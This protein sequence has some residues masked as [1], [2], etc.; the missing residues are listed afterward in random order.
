M[1]NGDSGELSWFALRVIP[2]RE[3]MVKK[4]LVRIGK[5]AFIKLERRFGKWINGE[6][7]DRPYC[8]APAYVFVGL[9]DEENPWD[10][11]HTCHLIRSVVSKEQQ[12]AKINPLILA[13]FLG[14]DDFD[15]P[16]YFKYFRTKEPDFRVGDMVRIDNPSFLGFKLP[17]K[18]I[19]RGEAIFDL[20]MFAGS[21]PA[22]I[23][24]PVEQCYKAA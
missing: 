1:S 6:R 11:V 12:P 18:D 20:V 14:F 17:V 4:H 23:R 10:F 19:Q 21:A 16:E 2:Q 5:K 24:I 22:E 13:D 9:G 3:D 15:M 7:T 8:A